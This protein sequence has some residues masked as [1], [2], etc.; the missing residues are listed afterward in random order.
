MCRC[1]D[2]G[3]TLA[4]LLFSGCVQ[5]VAEHRL[6]KHMTESVQKLMAYK[7]AFGTTLGEGT[8]NDIRSTALAEAA[9][10]PGA[11]SDVVV[12]VVVASILSSSA[13]M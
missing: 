13:S 7:P 11:S 9:K 12:A 8:V 2:S 5:A 3:S 4:S 10:L 1:L 6:E